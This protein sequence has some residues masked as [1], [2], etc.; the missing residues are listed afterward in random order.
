MLSRRLAL[1]ALLAPAPAF[2]DGPARCLNVEYTPTSGL[3]IVVWVED[4]SGNFLDTLFITQQTGSFGLGNRPGRYDFNSGPM[5]PYGRRLTTFPVW[6]HRNG[7]SFPSVLF[8]N[9]TNPD[10]NYCSTLDPQSSQYESC[11]ENQ[12]SH[13][14][15]NSS[16]ELHY[17]RP[18]MMSD[19]SWDT[20]T[21]AT[22]AFTDK[23]IFSTGSTT[24]YPP[25]IDVTPSAPDSMSVAM[26]ST[27]NPYDAVSQPTPLGGTLMQTP[28]PVPDSYAA[29][30]YTMYVEV[31]LEQDFN[32]TYNATSFP[33]PPNIAYGEYGVPYRGQPSIVYAVPFTI[34]DSA[35]TASTMQYVGYGDPTGSDGEIRPPDSTITT[36]TPG[37]GASRLQLVA[38][39]DGT[40]YR[41]KVDVTSNGASQLPTAPAQLQATAVT[42]SSLSMSFVAP[43]IGMPAG[44]VS[45]YEIRVR[46][47]DAMTDDNFEDS[48]MVTATVSP[49]SPG[50]TQTFDITGL[51]PLTDYWV[52]IRAYDG[53]HNTGDLTIVKVT[54]EDRTSGTVDACFVATA[55]YGSIMANDVEL[56]RHFR[57]TLL[58]SNVLGE[59]GVEAYYTFG[60]AVAGVVG[61]SELLRQTA[62]DVLVPIVRAV[63]RLKF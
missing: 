1:L 58:Q 23:G 54:T 16:R 21:C 10:P 52:G 46:A 50:S 53:C 32:D 43:G 18:L 3:Q 62:R 19:P 12:L 41:V 5:W 15:D 7:Q 56:L 55:A 57:D 44:K 27:L 34:G 38:G 2:A 47:N 25:R 6:S 63:R 17:C 31:S 13:S 37:T 42:S 29:G 40:M 4:A 30:S 28:W 49:D 24:G 60:P 22:Q 35:S 39:N 33:S 59:L 36:G 45:G 9:D 51:L 26:Y 20:M 61:E 14:F 8:Q 11:G 48:T